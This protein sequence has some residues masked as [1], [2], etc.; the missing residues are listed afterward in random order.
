MP[1]DDLLFF[2]TGHSLGGVTASKLAQELYGIH[3]SENVYVYSFATPKYALKNTFDKNQVF[4]NIFEII[5][6]YDTVSAYGWFGSRHA[7]CLKVFDGS[8][9]K[10]YLKYFQLLNGEEARLP[11]A[12]RGGIGDERHDVNL[13]MAYLLSKANSLGTDMYINDKYYL[14]SIKCPVNVELYNAEEKLV[15]KVV[16]NVCDETVQDENIVYMLYGDQKYFL[17]PIASELKIKMT[18]TAEDVMEYDVVKLTGADQEVGS[19]DVK[20]FEAVALEDGKTFSSVVKTEKMVSDT[21][22]YVT[23]SLTGNPVKEVLPDGK[24]TEIPYIPDDLGDV[25][26]EDIPED[27]KIPD[28]LWIAAIKEYTYTGA[29]IKPVPHVYDG[30]I[31]LEEKKDYTVSYKNN[32]NAAQSA[33]VKAPVIVIKGKGNYSGRETQ[34]F[35]IAKKNISDTDVIKTFADAYAIP[36]NKKSPALSFRAK[37]GNKVLKNKTDYHMSVKD[38]S[39]NETSSY[40]VQG[41]YTLTVRGTGTNYAGEQSFAFEVLDKIPVSNLKIS[42]IAPVTYDGTEKRPKLV[43]KY[44]TTT[45][46][47]DMDYG[48]DYQ[49]NMEKGTATITLKGKGAYFGTR[50]VSFAITGI[51]LKNAKIKGFINSMAYTASPVCQDNAVLEYQGKTLKPDT[52]YTISYSNN[53]HAGKATVIYTG[54]GSYEGTVKKMYKITAYSLSRDVGNR[55]RFG[56]EK[57]TVAYAKG[58]AKPSVTVYDR[59]KLLEEG[60]DYTLSYQYHTAVRTDAANK[61]PAVIVKGKGDYAGTFGGKKTF[62]I[63]AKDI[64]EV[65]VTAPD[66]VASPKPGKHRSVPVLTDTDGKKLQAGKDYDKNYVYTYKN[67]TTVKNSGVNIVRSSGETVNAGD[68]IPANTVLY[69]TVAAKSNSNYSGTTRPAEYRVTTASIKNAKVT[70][71]NPKMNNRNVFVYTGKEI[72]LDKNCLTVKVGKNTLTPDQYEILDDSYKN[73]IKKGTASVQ[74]RGTGEYYGGIKT[75]RFQIGSKG[76]QWFWRLWDSTA[77]MY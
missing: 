24:G 63:T 44:G 2:I 28:G 4:P 69:I 50:S 54:T 25:L 71:K 38:A 17:V 18:G 53:L 35:T 27:G 26:I 49:N 45:L 70:V 58:G 47:E 19:E 8:N 10:A 37:Y 3:R 75:I 7:G 9:E 76:F 23:D 57:I 68:I 29:A 16:N 41:A 55:I 61:A 46:V 52:D 59:E 6:Q 43:V 60:K 22:L 1:S 32:I 33:D 13:Y 77:K 15:C 48:L 21:T 40:A 67:V 20:V 73:N 62:T 66:I 30:Y 39:G 56:T 34:T 14:I 51:Q 11:K 12:K 72:R 31:R 36:G 42:K 5:N 74:I 64:A 65:S